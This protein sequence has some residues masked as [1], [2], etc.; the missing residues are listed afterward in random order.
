MSRRMRYLLRGE[1][2][3]KCIQYHLVMHISLG[4]ILRLH[5]C[6]RRH[7][8]RDGVAL[9]TCCDGLTKEQLGLP[10]LLPW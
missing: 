10:L 1:L 7:P 8:L 4:L 2:K 3:Y 6:R 9:R 5:W